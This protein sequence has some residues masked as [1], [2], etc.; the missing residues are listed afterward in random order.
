MSRTHATFQDTF[1]A[2]AVAVGYTPAKIAADAGMRSKLLAVFNRAYTRGY[3]LRTWEDAWNSATVTPASQ[4]IDFATLKDARRFEVWSA[5]PRDPANN[6]YPLLYTTTLNGIQLLENPATAFVLSLPSAPKFTTTAWVTSTAYAL[7]ALVLFTDGN[8]YRCI[9]A[10][11]SG[12]FATDL[13][14]AKWE[15]VPVLEILAEFTT[16]YARGTYILENGLPAEGAAARKDALDEL[17]VLSMNE[18]FRLAQSAWKPR[19]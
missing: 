14:A 13:A 12:T 1:D 16:A 15:L 6:A 11:T 5:D 18:H 4:I 7:K 3:N 10:H 8:V 19:G 17:E 9:T 2:L